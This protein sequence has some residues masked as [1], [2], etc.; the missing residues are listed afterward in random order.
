MNAAGDVSCVDVDFF[1]RYPLRAVW[2]ADQPVQVKTG[3]LKGRY[4]VEFANG[5]WL[6]IVARGELSLTEG[7]AG[8]PAI[9]GRFTINEYVARVIDREGSAQPPQA[10]RALA[11]AAR[12]YLVQNARFEAG[13]W[14]IAD[15]SRTQ[16]VSANPATVG[17]LA[18]TW[19]TDE[20]VL[21]GAPVQYHNDKPG[22]NRL[23]WRDAVAYAGQGWDFERILSTSYSKATIATL[24]GRA[25]CRRLVAAESWLAGIV[26]SWQARLRREPG[27]EPLEVPSKI[28]ALSDGHP[29]SDQQRL[30]IYVRGSR[31]LD[32]RITLAHEY[33]HLVFRFHP[34]GANEDY[35]E[36]LARRLIE[37]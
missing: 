11:I 25:E 19:F 32:E 27:F 13:C 21:S 14:R 6:S 16:R 1:T 36:R 5:N 15:S 20:I 3:D 4:W 37:G 9:S 31:S 28:C 35:I 18:A 23:A 22:A 7:A 17:A 34:N 30:R 26:G 24:L 33:L 12:S 29:Y 10:A 8:V 2:Q